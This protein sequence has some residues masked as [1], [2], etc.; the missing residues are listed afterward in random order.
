MLQTLF[1]PCLS[2]CSIVKVWDYQAALDPA[3]PDS[4]L[5]LA[6]LEVSVNAVTSESLRSYIYCNV[7]LQVPYHRYAPGYETSY[8]LYP[9]WNY[10]Y[11]IMAIKPDFGFVP[12]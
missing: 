1:N 3:S 11:F 12:N 6:T 10:V 9:K 8:I 4:S 7:F 2:L 5:C